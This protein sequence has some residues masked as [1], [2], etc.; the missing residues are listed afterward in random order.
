MRAWLAAGLAT[1]HSDFTP[2]TREFVANINTTLQSS[3]A[4][5]LAHAD[6]T[7]WRVID[8]RAPERFAGKVEPVD[9]VAG[10]VPG[11]LNHPFVRNLDEHGRWLD[12]TTLRQRYEAVLGPVLPS[13]TIMMC[14]SG[15]TAAHNLLAMEVAGLHGATLYAGSWSE[16]ITDP[17]RPVAK[18]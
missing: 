7:D 14:G 16:W 9:P 11:A 8:A 13:H 2:A 1:S 4:D 15:I 12:A 5:V 10:H 3:A 18:D 17:A 6:S